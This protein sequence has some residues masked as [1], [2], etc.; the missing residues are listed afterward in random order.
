MGNGDELIGKTA[1]EFAALI[2]SGQVSPAEVVLAH[3]HTHATHEVRNQPPRLAR[4]T[5]SPRMRP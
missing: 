1:P 4:T 5:S 2:Q 3:L